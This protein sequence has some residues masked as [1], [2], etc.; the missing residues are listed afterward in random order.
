MFKTN[1]KN[2][3]EFKLK[4]NTPLLSSY[5]KG[6]KIKLKEI[7]DINGMKIIY[8]AIRKKN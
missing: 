5:S 2:I 4:N 1:K 7:K 3:L 8:E 6:E